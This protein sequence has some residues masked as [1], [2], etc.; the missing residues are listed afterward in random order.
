LAVFERVT[1]HF[2]YHGFTAFVEFQ[3]DGIFDQGLGGNSFE[4][5]AGLDLETFGCAGFLLAGECT[6]G[7]EK[8][9]NVVVRKKW[10][11]GVGV[12][13]HGVGLIESKAIFCC[14]EGIK[15]VEQSQARLFSLLETE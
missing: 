6:Q 8:Q 9:G 4:C 1:G 2:K 12:V 11:C 13:L 5:E 15:K 3:V 7:K 14:N 10:A